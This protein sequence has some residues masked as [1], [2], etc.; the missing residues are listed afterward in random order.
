MSSL[1]GLSGELGPSP[2]RQRAGETQI[3]SVFENNDPRGSGAQGQD[4]R[5]RPGRLHLTWNEGPFEEEG[6]ALDDGGA[7]LGL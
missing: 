7:V 1:A 6:E 2:W 3:R 5:P 4:R